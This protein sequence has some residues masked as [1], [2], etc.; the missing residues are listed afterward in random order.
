MRSNDYRKKH[1]RGSS[2]PN[3]EVGHES[4]DWGVDWRQSRRLVPDDDSS[5]DRRRK[6]PHS[7]AQAGDNLYPVGD[8][9]QSCGVTS[10]TVGTRQ[11][12]LI[13]ST[14]KSDMDVS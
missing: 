2:P 13:N 11:H 6:E 12:Q 1:H 3:Q 14:G 7:D 10:S 4:D 8:R 5:G 9:G